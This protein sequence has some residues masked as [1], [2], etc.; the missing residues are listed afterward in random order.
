MAFLNRF[1]PENKSETS[2]AEYFTK[3]KKI[4][5]QYPQLP[6][7]HVGPPKKNTMV[8]MEVCISYSI[9]LTRWKQST[10]IRYCCTVLQNYWTSSS[11]AK[12]D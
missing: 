9:R 11:N 2:V 1:T 4:N 3:V 5:L 8:P 7:L 12:I 10:N 6:L